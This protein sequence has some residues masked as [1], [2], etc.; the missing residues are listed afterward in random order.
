MLYVK[1]SR[2]YSDSNE[3]QTKMFCRS[4]DTTKTWRCRDTIC[5]KT[6]SFDH[7]LHVIY[8]FHPI[9]SSPRYSVSSHHSIVENSAKSFSVQKA[10]GRSYMIGGSFSQL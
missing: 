4:E 2:C 6:L 3:K 9:C 10:L 7:A 1:H 8:Y 5:G